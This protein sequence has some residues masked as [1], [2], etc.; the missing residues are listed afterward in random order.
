L[1]V[2]TVKDALTSDTSTAKE[3][4]AALT[5]LA[6]KI[7]DSATKAALIDDIKL[8]VSKSLQTILTVLLSDSAVSSPASVLTPVKQL[9]IDVTA[10][11]DSPK[12]KTALKTDQLL[13]LLKDMEIPGIDPSCWT[14]L[15]QTQC[16][17]N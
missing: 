14:T 5:S 12:S 1:A 6:S 16:S 4:L 9:T 2:S 7:S 10:I 11:L 8:P 3:L 17:P 13:G 15:A